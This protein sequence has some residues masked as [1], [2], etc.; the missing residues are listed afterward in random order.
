MWNAWEI[1][2]LFLISLFLQVFLFLFG[3]IRQRSSCWLPR[4]FLW[5]AYLSADS[6]AVFVLGHLAVRASEPGHPLMSFWAPFVLVHLGGQDTIT[7]FS[8]QDNELYWRHPL[9]LVTQVAVA[10][11]IVGKASWPDARLRAAVALVF[12]SGCIKYVERIYFLFSASPGELRGWS[13]FHLSEKLK[14]WQ[15]QRQGLYKKIEGTREEA[16]ENAEDTLRLMLKGGSGRLADYVS[17]LIDIISVDAPL[18]NTHSITIAADD[19]PGMLEK[20]LSKESRHNAYEQC[21]VMLTTNSEV[22]HDSTIEDIV[23]KFPRF[24]QND[25]GKKDAVMK[26]FEGKVKQQED[27]KDEIQIKQ[28]K[29]LEEKQDTDEIQMEGEETPNIDS[30]SYNHMKKL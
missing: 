25:L 27:S 3:G 26:L 1:H 17:L 12:L 16:I 5:L 6:V 21:G 10:G 24:P 18:N 29:E 8:K 20:F 2:C 7:A 23:K 11:Y 22:V 4:T 28:H 13:R 14:G 9:N 15:R 19:L 30:G